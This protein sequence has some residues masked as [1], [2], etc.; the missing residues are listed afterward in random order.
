MGTPCQAQSSWALPGVA[1]IQQTLHAFERVRLRF[2]SF[3]KDMR[4][5]AWIKQ[6]MH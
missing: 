5:Q 1:Q 4:L 3:L 6:Q 2:A